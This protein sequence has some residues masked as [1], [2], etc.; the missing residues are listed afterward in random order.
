VTWSSAERYVAA[1]LR[2]LGCTD[3]KPLLGLRTYDSGRIAVRCRLCST[4][5]PALVDLFASDF[6]EEDEPIADVIRAFERGEKTETRRPVAWL[7]TVEA[8]R[9]CPEGTVLRTR[10]G[11]LEALAYRVATTDDWSV[12]GFESLWNAQHMLNVCER[13]ELVTTLEV[14]GD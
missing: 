7:T 13:W 9:A 3:P 12:T 6:F 14:D 11:H 8:L 10:A 1:H 2:A 5:L 4:T